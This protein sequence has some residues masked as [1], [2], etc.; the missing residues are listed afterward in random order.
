MPKLLLFCNGTLMRLA[1]GF[2]VALANSAVSSAA[3]FPPATAAF[4]PELTGV[5]CATTERLEL[6]K[7]TAA[8]R[9]IKR[10]RFNISGLK[11]AAYS[12]KRVFYTAINASVGPKSSRIGLQLMIF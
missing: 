7:V 10:Y 3:G 5:S 2:C 11:H 9:P 1:T 12:Q 4:G 8:A 6:H